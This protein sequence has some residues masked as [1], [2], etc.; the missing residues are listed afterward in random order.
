MHDCE[1]W[2][3]NNEA[4]KT[5]DNRYLQLCSIH[6]TMLVKVPKKNY[7]N[8]KEIKEIQI[9]FLPIFV[10]VLE[11]AEFADTILSRFDFLAY[12]CVDPFH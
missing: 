1:I 2:K 11:K 7:G 9:C 4:T 12:I 10:D 3:V 8:T 6:V 5:S